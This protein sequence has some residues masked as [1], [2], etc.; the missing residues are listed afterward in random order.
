[1]TAIQK[2]LGTITLLLSC[3]AAQNTAGTAT[4]QS[5][6]TAREGNDLRVEITTSSPVQPSIETAVHPDR[7]LLDFPDTA[8]NDTPKN[9]VVNA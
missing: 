5:V 6:T 1:M 7:I 9:V 4:V 2:Y 8:C 3:A